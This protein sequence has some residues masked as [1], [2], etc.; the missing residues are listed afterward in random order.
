MKKKFMRKYR[1][2]LLLLPIALLNA[3]FMLSTSR[4][5]WRI[6]F[7]KQ[8]IAA[9][10]AFLFH[11]SRSENKGLPNIIFILADD[12]GKSDLSIY[13]GTHL[14]TPHIDAIG[15]EGVVF[16]EAYV[17]APIC[18]PSRA[19][20]MT[21]RYQE[22]FGYY[23]QPEEKYPRNYLYYYMGKYFIRKNDWVLDTKPSYPAKKQ[24]KKQG[25]PPDEITLAE[26][27]K[28]K[29]Y[30]TGIIGKWHLGFENGFKPNQRGF[31]YQ[32]GFYSAFTL[33]ADKKD[34]KIETHIHHEFSDKYM[35]RKGR[36]GTGAILRNDT[37]VEEKEYLTFKIKDEA[38]HY[39][40]K[41]QHQ[42]FFLYLPFS[43]P[44]APYQVTKEYYNKFSWVT[45]HNKRVYYAMVAAFD[46]A[47]GEIMQKLKDL[48]LEEN[49]IIYF[50]SDNGGAS[51]I[52]AT[53][54]YPLKGGKFS[55]FEGG[56]NVP[57]MMKWKGKIPAGIVYNK[58]VISMDVFA[59]SI[60]ASHT[61]LPHD[62]VYD[63]RDLVPY[64]TGEKNE[65][66][67]T[68]LYWKAF[69]IKAM[70]KGDWKFIINTRDHWALLYNLKNDKSE[71]INLKSV[72][73]DV[74]KEMLEDFER[75]DKETKA[76]LWPSIM[77]YRFVIKDS[78]YLFPT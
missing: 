74:L 30:H 62:R 5:K 53:D 64:V 66:P 17:T 78:T 12:L 57:F 54:N 77:D 58:P 44:H 35:W 40:E 71:N 22:R 50:L 68:A 39:M 52:G 25:L 32:Y 67:H 34:P 61:E 29:G 11:K 9:K 3:C 69:H 65:D 73:P 70:R 38:I 42:P 14:N 51:Y 1:I 33:Y 24:I 21:G 37:L 63:G 2:V 41:H 55:T 60:A 26:L 45:D 31:D 76:P 75:W 4:R 23:V 43:A 49:T 28:A 20:I 48:N 8:E 13:G 16:N 7:D 6:R 72:K 47:V 15:R 19:A 18:S 59:S 27:L 36:S 56:I 10:E 46:D